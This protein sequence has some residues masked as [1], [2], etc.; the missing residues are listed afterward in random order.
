MDKQ[1][2]NDQGTMKIIRF[3]PGVLLT[4]TESSC[5]KEGAVVLTLNAPHDQSNSG[6]R[7]SKSF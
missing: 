4:G 3:E 7:N 2:N 6:Q 1:K 5:A